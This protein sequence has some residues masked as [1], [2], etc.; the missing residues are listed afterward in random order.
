MKPGNA[1]GCLVD[2]GRDVD[3]AEC[4]NQDAFEIEDIVGS[5]WCVPIFGLHAPEHDAE[6]L[7]L[8]EADDVVRF[9]RGEEG[10]ADFEEGA[11]F[12]LIGL[13]LFEGVEHGGHEGR[14][15]G[16]VLDAHGICNLHG[17]G[18]RVFGFEEQ[19]LGISGIHEGV[20]HAFVQSHSDEG[21]AKVVKTS[22]F[23]AVVE[24]RL[25]GIGGGVEGFFI[26]NVGTFHGDVREGCGEVIEAVAATDFFND[27][28]LA[29]DI[30]APGRGL[31]VDGI[32]IPVIGGE[33]DWFEV[34]FEFLSSEGDAQDIEDAFGAKGEGERIEL[35]DVFV[36]DGDGVAGRGLGE[37]PEGACGGAGD[38]VGVYE[39]FVPVTG[40]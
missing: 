7:R 16:G 13:V 37:E 4:G 14:A 32:G 9:G 21:F 3:G 19:F 40:F 2:L 34:S 10:F 33:A 26:F 31:D 6:A 25:A 8:I 18:F 23:G 12:L 27:V 38:A 35:S 22:T 29:S 17:A 5:R 20:V 39:A 28:D 30:G 15:H 24:I 1:F 36:I 11:C